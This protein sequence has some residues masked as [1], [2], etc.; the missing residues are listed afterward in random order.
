MVAMK[1]RR[2]RPDRLESNEE[3]LQRSRNAKG[4]VK[5]RVVFQI[6][7]ATTRQYVGFRGKGFVLSVFSPGFAARIADVAKSLFLNWRE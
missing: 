7:D 6:W 1:R 5:V 3:I 2:R 4:R